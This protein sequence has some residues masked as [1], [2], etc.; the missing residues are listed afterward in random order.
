MPHNTNAA[1]ALPTEAEIL[2]ASVWRLADWSHDETERAQLLVE[3]LWDIFRE[4]GQFSSD[5]GRILACLASIKRPDR[6]DPWTALCAL[7]ALESDA[8]DYPAGIYRAGLCV[9]ASFKQ[10]T[11]GQVK[12]AMDT[13][14][15]LIMDYLRN[16]QSAGS[17]ELFSHFA[18][19][20][21][22][23]PA[24]ESADNESITYVSGRRTKSVR[25]GAFA[26][27]VRQARKRIAALNDQ[28]ATVLGN[29]FLRSYQ[30]PV[31]LMAT[32]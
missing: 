16:N 3:S 26:E 8:R 4:Q 30:Q 15:G 21:G 5:D 29:V 9:L 2:E 11:R 1:T 32:E 18:R 12:R 28:P 25:R 14:D 24:I 23:H 31:V 20:A 10:A 22:M 19:L 6:R 17:G 13:L 27:R 7:L